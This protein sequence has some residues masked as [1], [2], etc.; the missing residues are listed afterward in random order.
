MKDQYALLGNPVGHSKSPHIHHAFAR[1]QG[2][3]LSYR[4]IE[5]PLGSFAEAARA[6]HAGGGR[7]MNITAPFKLDAFAF[8]TE[9]SPRARQ[10][11]AVNSLKF[12]GER[13]LGENFDGIGLVNDIQRNLKFPLHGKRV[14]LLG[15]GGA[16]R[17]AI[18]PIL[19]AQPARLTVANRTDRKAVALA[20]EFA[21][22]GAVH[23]SS[24][25][26]LAGEQFDI[27]L[28]ATSASLEAQRPPLPDHAY[29]AGAMAYDLVYGKG[30]TPFLAH[31]RSDGAAHLADGFGM[32]VEQAAET[33]LWWRG[34]RPDTASVIAELSGPLR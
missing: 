32:V 15:A 26:E 17:G 6:F 3:E 10:A 13:I 25:G 8:A 7:G 1:A 20:H 34:V 27:I 19:E 12:D 24:Y 21:D 23:P 28:N 30:L 2:H 29:A 9:L 22:Y 4:A 11:R 14:L 33:Y 18:V 5:A 16:T 31:A